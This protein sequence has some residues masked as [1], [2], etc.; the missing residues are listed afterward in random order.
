MEIFMTQQKLQQSRVAYISV[1][2]GMA[3]I[4]VLIPH[5]LAYRIET[6]AFR[7]LA[8]YVLNPLHI[9]QFTGAIG[10]S[11][12]FITSGY[13]T[14][15]QIGGEKFL[16]RFLKS[17]VMMVIQVF[18]AIIF[19]WLIVSI[20]DL[21]FEKFGYVSSYF[22]YTF[23]D[24]FESALLYRNIFFMES[25]EAALWF[26][27]PFLLFK[28]LLLVF[29]Y[30]CQG[31]KIKVLFCFWGGFIFGYVLLKQFSIYTF[32]ISLVTDRFFI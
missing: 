1:L 30:F 16:Q 11:I 32:N 15:K 24:W 27:V 10:V 19:V 7:Y 25:C 12:F 31:D 2:R 14:L 20:F 4:M 17:V 22:N 23:K 18:I 13:L 3:M 6:T 29:D 8:H 21:I 9:I 26:L 28:I 5:I